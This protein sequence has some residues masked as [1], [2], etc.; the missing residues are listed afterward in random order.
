MINHLDRSYI[1]QIANWAWR[2][3]SSY[4]SGAVPTMLSLQEVQMLEWLGRTFP[5]QAMEMIVDAG[6]FLGG[7]TH[8]I[9][10]GLKQNHDALAQGCRIHSYDHFI[11]PESRFVSSLTGQMDAG[12]SFYD[13]Y[14]ENIS[15]VKHVVEIHAGDFANAA[16]PALIGVLFVDVAKSS[17]LNDVVLDRFFPAMIPGRTILIQQDHNDHYCVWI[18][19][20]M[21]YF[22]DH[23]EYLCDDGGGSRVFLFTKAFEQGS[24]SKQLQELPLD[25]KIEL[26][27]QAVSKA[28]D[29]VAGY[30]S[31]VSTAWLIADRDQ[32]EALD[33]LRS[34]AADQPWPSEEPYINYVI[35]G[36]G[37]SV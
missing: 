1:E 25:R 29:P 33:Y 6:A 4:Q 30:L 21:E 22:A 14:L 2:D 16:A 9:A 28:K 26:C 31:R 36:L 5:F 34:I 37:L 35:R 19:L 32:Y 15:E 18:N 27:H 8:A 7:S 3:Q 11:A 17:E 24:L 20:T 12:G 23:F 13:I 10:T